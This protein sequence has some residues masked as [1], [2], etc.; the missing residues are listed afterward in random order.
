MVWK[1]I[2]ANTPKTL[3]DI[4]P[5]L[6][7]N[8][9]TCL[10][11]SNEDKRSVAS[12]TLGDLVSKLGE[13]VLPTI[14]P[15]LSEGLQSNNPDT[16]SGVCLGLT[17]VLGQAPRAELDQ[18]M[19][20]IIPTVR[21]A[22]CDN[23]PEVREAA[24][25]SFDTLFRSVG[26][27]IIHEILP[28]LLEDM[29]KEDLR[30]H[31]L[32]GLKE[33]LIVRSNQVLPHLI[34]ELLEPPLTESNCRALASV[35][36][37]SGNAL[38]R[39]IDRILPVLVREL[40]HNPEALEAGKAV[41]LGIQDAGLHLLFRELIKELKDNDPAVRQGSA[42][43]MELFCAESKTN[44]EDEYM[45]SIL[46]SLI[47]NLNDVDVS[48]QKASWQALSVVVNV[49]LLKG[50]KKKKKHFLLICIQIN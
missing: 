32:E 39:H 38:D 37:V 5:V 2:V 6:M 33:V 13:L 10:G 30:A 21:K 50:K 11:S 42:I 22:L 43:L 27:R 35:A 49:S 45:F 36:Q 34:P 28:H 25:Q 1:T 26:A 4:L 47:L 48:V 19:D 31:A 24:A 20:D 29:Q 41:V 9:I 23:L 40:P 15:I 17:E 7:R 8:I 16:R 46:R 3:K 18:Y 44:F 14:I 12:R